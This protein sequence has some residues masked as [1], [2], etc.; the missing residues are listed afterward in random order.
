MGFWG[1]VWPN[2]LKTGR[3]GRKAR[4]RFNHK[5]VP[6]EIKMGKQGQKARTAF[7]KDATPVIGA[8]TIATGLYTANPTL[9]QAGVA[10]ITASAI[11]K[12]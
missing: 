10:V 9:I 11:F 7:V 8:A 2:E 12:T 5:Y 1:K 6:N 4:T 3:T